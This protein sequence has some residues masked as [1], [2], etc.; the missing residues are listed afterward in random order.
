MKQRMNSQRK[1]FSRGVLSLLVIAS[2]TAFS[3]QAVA[4]DV[5]KE[6]SKDR[7]DI[8]KDLERAGKNAERLDKDKTKEKK[9]LGLSDSPKKVDTTAERTARSPEEIAELKRQIE[10]KNVELIKKLDKLIQGDPYSPSRPDWMFQKAELLWELRNMEY[11]RARAE[12]NECLAAS[13][14]GNIDASKCEEPVPEYGEAQEIYSAILKEY[15]DYGRLDEVIYRLGRGLIEAGKG[16]EAVDLLNRLVQNYPNSVYKPE[17]HLALG[18]F[19]F[20][21]D[22]YNLAKTHYNDTMEYKDYS[23]REYAR[24]KLGWTHYNQ[25]NYRP[26]IETFKKVVEVDDQTLGFRSQALNDLIVAFAQVEGGWKEAR[27]YFLD[28]DKE[29]ADVSPEDE[30]KGNKEYA[31]K[32]MGKMAGYLE[33]Q[34]QDEDA[35]SIYEWFIEERPNHKNMPQWM[36]SIVI[37]KKKEVNN[38]AATEKAMN[39]FIAY[40]DP[41]GT[42]Y[43][44]NKENEGSISNAALLTEASLAYLSNVYHVRAQKQGDRE[45]YKKAA[46][47]YERFIERF[48]NKPASFDMNYLLGEIYLFDL[49]RRE[50]AAKQYQKVVDLYKQDK[51]P[52]GVKEKEAEKIVKDSAYAVVN[53]YN[54][55]VKEKCE[56]SILVKMAEAAKKSRDG[57]YRTKSKMDLKE[58]KPNPKVDIAK[59]CK[60]ELAFVQAS[61]QWSEMYP[62]DNATPTVDYVTAEVYKARGHYD[63]CVPRY[64]NIIENAPKDHPYRSFAGASLLDANYRLERWGE[65]EKWARYLMENKI[66]DVTPKEGLQSTIAFA[67]NE[68]AKDL[69]EKANTVRYGPEYMAYVDKREKALKEGAEPPE[70]ELRKTTNPEK[71]AKA[72][73]TFEKAASELL[74][75]ADEFPN[76][77]L[78][79]GAVFNAAAIY[80]SGEQIT[81]AIETYERVVKMTPKSDEAKEKQLDRAAQALFVMGAIYESRADFERAAEY[82]GRLAEEK[83]REHEK[84]EPAIYNAGNLR[85]AMEQWDKS[86]NVFESYISLY[87]DSEDEDVQENIRDLKLLLAH[88]EQRRDQPKEALDRFEDF[89]DEAKDVTP[90]EKIEVYTEIGLI[91]EELKK[92]R[93]ERD[94]DEAYGKAVEIYEEEFPEYLKT[95]DKGE[96]ETKDK[97]AR[98][99]ISQSKFMQAERIYDEFAAVKLNFPM[100]KLTRVWKRRERLSRTLRR[101]TS[102]SLISRIRT[103]SPQRPTASGRCIRTSPMSST[104]CRCPRG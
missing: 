42:W 2:L 89:L 47:Y 72:R 11:L 24:Y 51:I 41:Q 52:D 88:L 100:R 37:A 81:K 15:S 18:E 12:Y 74:R 85:R 86:I 6:R 35:V 84:A 33:Q 20:D 82:F 32:Q 43:Q 64:E 60:Y 59:E 26:A 28:Y 29:Y 57:V 97:I 67:I 75:L 13:D 76:S 39:R 9:D 34:G 102:R 49:E 30:V 91:H 61:D 5:S 40:L 55:L 44:Q 8:T 17:A 80:E 46:E 7:A 36:E 38:L 4:Q 78:A 69:Q 70:M 66:F 65:V 48:P 14:A 62:K 23:F 103:T 71:L 31:Y 10:K 21:K 90:A 104:I 87:K 58:D 53:S 45:D 68:K 22:I 101:S 96:K 54:E 77:E 73:D 99:Y 27:T 16:A 63:K 3:A 92:R 94:A 1:H 95:L 93:W 98:K 50:Q 83:Y 25:Q 79:P 56:D 19:Y